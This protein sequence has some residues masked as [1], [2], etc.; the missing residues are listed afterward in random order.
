[1]PRWGRVWVMEREAYVER[2][3]IMEI[4]GKEAPVE[5]SR[6]ASEYA[7]HT[8]LG[9][10]ATAMANGDPEPAR[11]WVAEIA[12]RWGQGFADELVEEI[13]LNIEIALNARR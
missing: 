2:R 1:M 8:T 11:K 6:V 4:D 13:D 7:Y 12:A 3:A 9:K 10:V 5:A